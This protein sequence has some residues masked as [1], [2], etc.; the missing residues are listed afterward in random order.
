MLDHSL[1]S[2]DDTFVVRHNETIGIPVVFTA[3]GNAPAKASFSISYNPTCL[4]YVS[5]SGG[6]GSAAAARRRHMTVNA[7]GS[8]IVNGTLVTLNFT[9]NLACPSGT[10]VPLAFTPA[11]LQRRRLAGQ[12]RQRPGPR[13]C[14]QRP[15]RLQQ[16][17]L[18]QRR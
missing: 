17:R 14:Q 9:A 18:R 2:I 11:S 15:R 6:T 16:R 3:N 5:T 13:D 1:L 4:T 7:S 8:P 10:S 12:H